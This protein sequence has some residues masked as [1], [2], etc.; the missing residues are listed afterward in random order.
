MQKHNLPEIISCTDLKGKYVLVRV[1]LNVPV[2]D[3]V[4]LNAFRIQQSL[5]TITYLRQ[6]GAKVILCSHIGKSPDETLAPVHTALLAYF[7]VQ[8]SPEVVGEATTKM[9]NALQDGEVLLLENVRR[10][11]REIENDPSFAKELSLLAEVF[12]ND[13]FAASHRAHASLHAICALLPSYVGINFAHEYTEL[14]KAMTPESPS[15]FMIGGAKFETKM[16]LVEKY[17]P[18]YDHVFIGGALANDFFKGK[19]L[20]VGTS[21]VSKVSLVGSS[22]LTN[23]QVLLIG[24]A[25]V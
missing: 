5:P 19:G 1:S 22:L 24:R 3:G 2:K 16:P 12:V 11:S 10:D 23:P 9:R 14:S 7:P 4:V 13:D 20:E 6:Q 18:I 15:L 21:L 8:F 25:H 17:L